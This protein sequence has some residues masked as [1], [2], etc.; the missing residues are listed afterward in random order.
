MSISRFK[1][2]KLVV[3]A[4]K[5]EMILR[6]SITRDQLLYLAEIENTVLE[7]EIAGDE[8]ISERYSS[9]GDML[10]ANVTKLDLDENTMQ[11]VDFAKRLAGEVSSSETRR[12]WFGSDSCWEYYVH[13]STPWLHKKIDGKNAPSDDEWLLRSVPDQKIAMV[14]MALVVWDRDATLRTGARALR[15]YQDAHGLMQK[16]FS[17]DYVD[18]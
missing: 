8:E 16:R 18:E 15:A 14:D 5:A 7:C 4:P 10:H 11:I 12:H 6:A 1:R 17:D 13:T 9:I 3:R 2:R